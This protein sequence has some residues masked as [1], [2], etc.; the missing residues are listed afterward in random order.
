MIRM[1][2]K[3]NFVSPSLRVVSGLLSVDDLEVGK[4]G[5]NIFKCKVK[6][7]EGSLGFSSIEDDGI[8]SK[9][10]ESIKEQIELMSRSFFNG[11]ILR[12]CCYH[13]LDELSS[14]NFLSLEKKF[15]ERK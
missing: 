5:R 9:L 11:V 6:V 7:E 8:P 12:D 14:D 1:N 15:L 13:W 4:E 10:F 3:W 2:I